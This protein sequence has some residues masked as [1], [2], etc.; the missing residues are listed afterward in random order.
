MKTK[1]LALALLAPMAANAQ[2]VGIWNRD[3]KGSVGPIL[4]MENYVNK[5]TVGA[6]GIT[7]LTC[8]T[9]TGQ[10]Y[11]AAAAG[12]DYETKQAV[13]DIMPSFPTGRV[14]NGSAGSPRTGART[15]N[16]NTTFVAFSA[17]SGTTV[18]LGCWSYR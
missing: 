4:P 17:I 9:G 6:S 12:A 7:S 2:N 3:Q 18:Y 1:L 5:A 8:P 13:S 14:T 10:F 16:P 15:W 11:T